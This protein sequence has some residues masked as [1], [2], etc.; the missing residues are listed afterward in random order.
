MSFKEIIRIRK[1]ERLPAAVLMV[2][3]LVLNTIF[4]QRVNEYILSTDSADMDLVEL[5][6]C[7]HR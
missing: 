4:V 2:L 7:F 5:L 1:E 3:A 6:R